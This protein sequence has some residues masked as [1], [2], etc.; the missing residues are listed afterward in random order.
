MNICRLQ[1]CNGDRTLIILINFVVP[2]PV[3]ER[4]KARVRCR[5]LAVI[6]GLNPAG[7]IDVCLLWVLCVVRLRSLQ[8]ADYSSSGVLLTDVTVWDLET[9]AM[10]RPWS[11]LGRRTEEEEKGL[12]KPIPLVTV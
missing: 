8:R 7:G 11:P 3:A 4:C 2:I 9:L 1:S 6:A 10:R 12:S 5:S